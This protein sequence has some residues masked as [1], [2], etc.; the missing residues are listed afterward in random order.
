[1]TT[2]QADQSPFV[3]I[4]SRAAVQRRTPT[5]KEIGDK[6]EGEASQKQN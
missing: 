5:E 1:M 4:V 3:A 2:N 6:K